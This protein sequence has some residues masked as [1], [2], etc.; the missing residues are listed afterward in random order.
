MGRFASNKPL[1]GRIG[2][3]W[4]Y[5]S[6]TTNI[7]SR[8]LRLAI[9]NDREYWSYPYEALF[10]P[11]GMASAYLETDSSGNFVASSLGWASARDWARFGLL[12][13]N[14]GAWNGKQ[15]L[16]KGWIQHA[17]TPSKGSKK[18]YGAHWWLSSKRRRPDLPRDSYSAE[19][20]EGQLI[21]VVPSSKTVIVR[22]GQTPKRIS[23][24][25]NNFGALIL[26]ALNAQT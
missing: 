9:N 1:T 26:S 19:G 24:N 4:S 18:G 16:Q 12:Y 2:R 8:G 6:G 23:F 7:L 3:D 10:K 11:L 21:L 20:Y 13:L 17:T 15:I 5:S 14:K 22:L 25:P